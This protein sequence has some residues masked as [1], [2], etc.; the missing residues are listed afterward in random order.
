MEYTL[1]EQLIYFLNNFNA[2]YINDYFGA[3]FSYDYDRWE[4]EENNIKVLEFLN[5]EFINIDNDLDIHGTSKLDERVRK[6][7][8][9]ALEMLK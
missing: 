1:K 5:D 7:L 2:K 8:E 9:K 4:K 6:C 3:N